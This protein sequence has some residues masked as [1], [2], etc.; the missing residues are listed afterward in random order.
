MKIYIQMTGL[1][2]L[3]DHIIQICCYVTD[4]NMTFLSPTPFEATVHA[5]DDIL[6]SMDEWCTRVHAGTGL[7]AKS[8][9][10]KLSIEAAADQLLQYIRYLVPTRKMGLL[11][12]NSVHFD[13]AFLAKWCPKVIDHLN[14]RIVDVSTV[15]EAARMWC[16]QEVRGN[17]PVKEMKHEAK[18]DILESIEEMKYYKEKI[19]DG[20]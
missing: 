8:R 2:P 5:P 18:S 17:I 20:K 10:S 11:A 19:F 16:S 15:G 6:D 14:Y 1:D 9:E 4:S 3:K 7:T 12:G 13:K